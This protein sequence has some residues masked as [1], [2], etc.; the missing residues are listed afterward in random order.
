MNLTH[1]ELTNFLSHKHTRFRI[2]DTNPVIVVGRN[3]AGKSTLVKDAVTWALFGKSRTDQDSLVH[4][5]Q[6]HMRV[7]VRFF[8]G[9]FQYEVV[10]SREKY[11]RG[12]KS[13]LELYEHGKLAIGATINETQEKINILLGM[14]Y[15]T[16][17]RT[18]C[19]E[20][21]KAGAFS[22]LTP[23]EAKKTL[24]DVL[25]LGV[26]DH[27]L[28]E[29]KSQM[30][31]ITAKLLKAE[32]EKSAVEREIELI[33]PKLKDDNTRQKISDLE[34]ELTKK[35]EECEE[36]GIAA[37][38][39]NKSYNLDHV[40]LEKIEMYV[41]Q[42]EDAKLNVQEK[43]NKVLKAGE[44]GKCPLCLTQLNLYSIQQVTREFQDR[45]SKY[46]SELEK[47]QTKRDELRMK[48]N[49]ASTEISGLQSR[50]NSLVSEIRLKQSNLISLKEN[51]AVSESRESDVDVLRQR[52]LEV[53]R[54][55]A[56]LQRDWRVHGV[57]MRAFDRNGIPTLIIENAIPEIEERAN[58]ILEILTDDR[59][60]LGLKTQRE[61]KKGGLGETLEIEIKDLTND[62]KYDILSGGE[63]FRVDLALRVALSS[64]LASRSNFQCE[65][66][67]I[68]EGFGSLDDI[69]RLK[70]IQLTEYLK[71]TFKRILVV[72]HTDLTDHY[73]GLVTVV[74][75]NGV[76]TINA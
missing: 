75:E 73:E 42:L 76:S 50:I 24:L 66:L 53:S 46:Q 12:G 13:D 43:L 15:E 69:G 9:R 22:E 49:T 20:Q 68:D 16:F 59:M 71:P 21:G 8:L 23:K 74:K 28:T 47:M 44:R 29:V 37:A 17:I 6:D 34:I 60:M 63:K 64:V 2:S 25:Q 56:S 19:I 32:A 40:A 36:L 11:G 14:N 4:F 10:R 54:Q 30:G 70:F 3:G 18:A 26:Y 31:E 27:Y 57:L 33:Q 35:Q 65:T 52:H 61:L 39:K 7:S 1:I 62:K 58:K 67:I 48:T 45:L 51:K 55:V 38:E 5:G 41:R 72:T